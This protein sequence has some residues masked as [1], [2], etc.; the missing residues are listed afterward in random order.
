MFFA[1]GFL[2]EVRNPYNADAEF[3]VMGNA[4]VKSGIL[5]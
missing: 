3:E 1:A 2:Q 5:H 4:P